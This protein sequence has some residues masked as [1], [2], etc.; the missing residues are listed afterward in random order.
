M[1]RCTLR[2]FAPGS[3]SLFRPISFS[4]MSGRRLSF[5]LASLGAVLIPVLLAWFMFSSWTRKTYYDDLDSE[6]TRICEASAEVLRVEV[7]HFLSEGRTLAGEDWFLGQLGNQKRAKELNK[8]PKARGMGA[9]IYDQEGKI[10]ASCGPIPPLGRYSRWFNAVQEGKKQKISPEVYVEAGGGTHVVG[11]LSVASSKAN[12]EAHSMSVTRPISHFLR[13][14]RS[15]GGRL[16]AGQNLLVIDGKGDILYSSTGRELGVDWKREES[17]PWKQSVSGTVLTQDG[18]P[19][20][21]HA[22]NVQL[23][24]GQMEGADPWRVVMVTNYDE[25]IQLQPVWIPFL[26]VGVGMILGFALLRVFEQAFFGPLSAIEQAVARLANGETGFR[27]PRPEGEEFRRLVNVLNSLVL[28]MGRNR[29]ALV[30][31]VQEKNAR[32]RISQESLRGTTV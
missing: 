9:V 17:V 29:E 3:P 2:S 19:L 25:A 4:L 22:R 14:L 28:T 10:L 21:F 6:A 23:R 12:L 18:N 24:S 13:H 7:E 8:L 1:R 15:Y 26:V 30:S 5:L 31:A 16:R 32:L 11:F 20:V 27:I